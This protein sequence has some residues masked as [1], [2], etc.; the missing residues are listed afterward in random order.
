MAFGAF[1]VLGTLMVDLFPECPATATAAN[2]ITRC[3]LGAAATAVVVPMIKRIGAGWT[4]SFVAGL[5]VCFVPPLWAVVRWGPGMRAE[6]ERKE[7][8]RNERKEG[9]EGGRV[10]D[11]EKGGVGVEMEKVEAEAMGGGEEKTVVG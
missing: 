9:E 1:T 10:G 7:K 6:K 8:E 11:V 4:F 2:N 5:W 3:W